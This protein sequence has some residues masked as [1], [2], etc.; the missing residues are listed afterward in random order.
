MTV[1]YEFT[2]SKWNPNIDFGSIVSQFN[3]E[4]PVCSCCDE[5]CEKVALIPYTNGYNF[6]QKLK[7]FA[8]V[9]YKIT[10]V[11]DVPVTDNGTVIDGTHRDYNKDDW[12]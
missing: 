11:K 8:E 7:Q 3:G 5:Y 9:E 12:Q 6:E 2:I 4:R 1:K 10:G